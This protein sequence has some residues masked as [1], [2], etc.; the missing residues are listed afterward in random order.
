MASSGS[1]LPEEIDENFLLCGICCER[2]KNPKILPCLHSFCEPCLGKLADEMGAITCPVCRR[3]H[4]LTDNGVA[5]IQVNIFLNDLITLF[6]QQKS[7]NTSKKC[8]GCEQ[9]DAI[10]HCTVCSFDFCSNCVTIHGKLPTTKSHLLLGFDEYMAAKSADPASVQPPVYCNSHQDYQVEFYCDTCNTVICLKCTALDHPLTKHQY[11]CV[12]DAAKHFTE[13]LRVVIDKVKVKET[14]ANN[15]KLKVQQIF[16]SLEKCF[17]R[18]EESLRKHIRQIIDEITRLIQENGNKLLTELKGEYEKRKVNLTAQLK[19]L[20][21]AESDL[22]STREYVEK[23]MHYGNASQLM[24]A[25]R[26]VDHQTEELLKVQT[27][28]EPVEDDYMEFQQCDDF[29]RGKS[30]GTIKFI[31]TVYKVDSVTPTVRVGEDITCTIRSA[32]E[33]SLNKEEV[34]YHVQVE[35]VMKTPNGN[36][37]KVEVKDN[38]NGTMTLKTRVEVEGEHELSVTVCKKPVE[39]SPVN[40]KVI[41]KKG[42]MCKFGEKG[43]GVGQFN[44]IRGVTMMGN[45]DVLVAEYNNQI[46]QNFTVNGRHRKMFK[47]ANVSN[48]HPYDAAVSVNGNVFTTDCGNNQV[49]VCDENGELI[50]CFGKGK[51]RGPIGIAIS[52]VN[53]RVYIVDYVAHCIHI[54]DQDGN[55]IKSFGSNGSQKGQFSNP[56]FVCINTV[57]NVYVSDAG[58]Y[59]IQVFNGD[60]YFLYTFGSHGSGDGQ[61]NWPQGVAMDKHGYVYVTEYINNRIVKYESN[62]KFVCRIDDVSDGLSSPTGVCVTDDDRVIVADNGNS[63]IKVFT[64]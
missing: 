25:K 4:E 29:C 50:R 19:E 61:M 57:G 37:Q 31:P 32:N 12:K 30:L 7:V 26:R 43:L 49:I 13:N 52:P 51:I 1:Q 6:E 10:N 56:W 11:R 24:S 40:I 16:E 28:V 60:G 27:Q 54:Y 64:Q 63:C 18:E 20:D 55:H 58:N 9:G 15:S 44:D 39:G 8:D 62:G 3:V 34:S 23:L 22:T 36:T 33:S 41:A 48:F 38:E 46:L 45:G 21:I 35:A 2:Y 47:F 14:E 5:G 17:Q 53:G 42:L 59:R